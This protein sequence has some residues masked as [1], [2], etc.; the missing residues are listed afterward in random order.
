[1]KIG[2]RRHIAQAAALPESRRFLVHSHL[3]APRH[4]ARR[5][6]NAG[7]SSQNHPFLPATSVPAA[8]NPHQPGTV[9]LALSFEQPVHLLGFRTAEQALGREN[10][11][12]DAASAV[13]SAVDDGLAERTTLLSRLHAEP[14]PLQLRG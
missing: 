5:A 13:T 11:F 14:T 10:L 12:A 3:Q 2:D 1:M 6:G 9:S 8:F 7:K 4:G